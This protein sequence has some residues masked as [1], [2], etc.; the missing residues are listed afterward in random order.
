VP[1]GHAELTARDRLIVDI[2]RLAEQLGVSLDSPTIVLEREP[3][4]GTGKLAGNSISL[5]TS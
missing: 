3:I 1:D 5:P 2:L 4:A